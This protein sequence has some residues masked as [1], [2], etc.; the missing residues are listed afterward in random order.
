M[1]TNGRGVKVGAPGVDEAGETALA[2]VEGA[3]LGGVSLGDFAGAVDFVVGDDEDAPTTGCGGG[4]D[5]DRVEQ[6]H[7]AIGAH[8]RGRAHG[9]DQDDRFGGTDDEV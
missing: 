2:A 5:G 7:R 4:G 3:E 1:A 8:G 9:A 6:I